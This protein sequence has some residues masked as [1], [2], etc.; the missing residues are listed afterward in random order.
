[1]EIIVYYPETV[2]KQAE[3]EAMVTKFHSEYVCRY[4]ERLRCPVAQ[5]LALIDAVASMA[6]QKGQRSPKK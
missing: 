6:S 1:M 2:D 5:K 3:F 4:I